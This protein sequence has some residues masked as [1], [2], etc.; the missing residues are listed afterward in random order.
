M[1]VHRRLRSTDT[2]TRSMF[3]N[4]SPTPVELVALQITTVLFDSLG[5]FAQNSQ[6]SVT[7]HPVPLVGWGRGGIW[8]VDSQE[9]HLKCCHQMSA[10]KAKMHQNLF[11]LQ[12]SPDP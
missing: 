8:A 4:R 11:P 3:G 7:M 2:A 5:E 12:R 6:E 9:N 1:S 10:L